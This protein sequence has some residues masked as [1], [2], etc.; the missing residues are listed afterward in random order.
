[1]SG[2]QAAFSAA[3]ASVQSSHG[4]AQVPAMALFALFGLN[5][6]LE[7]IARLLLGILRHLYGHT[8]AIDVQLRPRSPLQVFEDKIAQETVSEV[9]LKQWLKNDQPLLQVGMVDQTE[10]QQ[11]QVKSVTEALKELMGEEEYKRW[12]EENIDEL[13]DKARR[14]AEG[15][16]GKP[17][18]APPGPGPTRP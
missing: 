15:T 8:D 9:E 12:S 10:D 18:Q 16:A 11:A 2:F 3:W 4:A 14:E 6:S 7:N 17:K 1:M 5:N 13:W